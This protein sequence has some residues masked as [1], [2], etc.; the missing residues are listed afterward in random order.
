MSYN[1]SLFQG[2]PKKN[3]NKSRFNLSHEH[4]NQFLPGNL[5]PCLL[6]ETLPGDEFDIQTEFMFRFS[7]LYFPIMHKMTMRADY[8]YVPNRI[9]WPDVGGGNE[10]WSKWISEG[11][12]VDRPYMNANMAF[13]AAAYSVQVLAHMGLPLITPV[14]GS[15]EIISGLNALPLSAYLKIWDEY[16]RVTQLEDEVW[17]P[18]SGGD[19]T[20]GFNLAFGVGAGLPW[21]SFNSN[22]EKD[23]FTSALPTPQITN[24][25]QIEE[26]FEGGPTTWKKIV[27]GTPADAG[28][29]VTTPIGETETNSDL[30]YLEIQNTNTVKAIRLAEVLQ[31][32]YERIMKVGQRYRDFIEGLWGNDPEPG[33]VDVPV[34]F[35]STFGR[36][37]IAD[38][39]TN[40]S[41]D[42]GET[43]TSRTGDYA[44]QA[45]L[46]ESG[47]E[48]HKYN[49]KEHGWIM[50]ILQVNPNTNYGQ[51]IERFWR[52]SIQTDYPLDIFSGIGDQEILKEEVLYNPITA[53]VTKNSETFGYIPRFSEMRYKNNLY[54]HNLAF[55]QG[56]LSQHL[57]RWWDPATTVGAV[58]DSTI[59]IDETFIKAGSELAGGIRLTDVFRILPSG[60]DTYP[61]EGVI[62]GHLFHSIYVNRALPMFSTPKL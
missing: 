50:C 27:D 3:V 30:V 14:V 59:Q 16:Y 33:V 41:Y 25:F 51:G 35:G 43:G 55:V 18:L 39:M 47:N 38:V 45:N 58:Y 40:A 49:C 29:L 7:P 42:Y 53:E 37:Q 10:G 22:W 26:L 2:V 19:N 54:V 6:L 23:Y 5:I 9:L 46:Y 1:K 4:K 28:D 32:Y 20:N 15:D 24:A 21:K 12:E 11:F 31:S 48:T 44:G 52:R 61:S 17:F 56:G 34:L 60:D 36:V 57:G 13:T 8:Y 62:Y